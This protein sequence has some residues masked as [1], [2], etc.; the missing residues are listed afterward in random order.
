MA[1]AEREV[2]VGERRIQW[3]G[4]HPAAAYDGR[5]GARRRLRSS[6]GRQRSASAVHRRLLVLRGQALRPGKAPMPGGVAAVSRIRAVLAGSAG[7][8]VEWFDW[9]TYSAAALYFAPI[10]FPKG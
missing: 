10:F 4:V 3:G 6:R 5:R 7:N 9:Y 2:D 1:V 8:L